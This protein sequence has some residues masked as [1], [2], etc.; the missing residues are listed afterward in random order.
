MVLR[1]LGQHPHHRQRHGEFWQ[2]I[3]VQLPYRPV[4]VPVAVAIPREHDDTI[5]IIHVDLLIHRYDV[6]IRQRLLAAA[7]DEPRNLHEG[8]V[9]CDEGWEVRREVSVGSVAWSPSG[10]KVAT[11]CGD[12]QLRIVDGA[13]GDVEKEVRHEGSVRSVAWSP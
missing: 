3:W 6:R 7:N 12:K 1:E 2:P 4:T 11:G 13:T 10:R 8:R 5:G 9:R